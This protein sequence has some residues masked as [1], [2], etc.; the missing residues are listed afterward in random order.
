MI[1][2][3]AAST[4]GRYLTMIGGSGRYRAWTRG[5]R[6]SAGVRSEPGRTPVGQHKT[7]HHLK[8]PACCVPPYPTRSVTNPFSA[9]L[10]AWYI[11]LGLRP[12]SPSTRI[13]TDRSEWWFRGLKTY[14]RN[15]VRT[16]NKSPE[17][18]KGTRSTMSLDP[19]ASSGKP[20]SLRANVVVMMEI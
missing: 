18:M 16:V 8:P 1:L 11:I 12:I 14:H 3:G 9:K 7:L 17:A 20:R 19:M 15:A 5:S 4:N 13:A 6:S 2:M 10:C